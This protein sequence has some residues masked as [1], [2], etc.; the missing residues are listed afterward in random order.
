MDLLVS[1]NV[2]KEDK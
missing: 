2:L 1:N